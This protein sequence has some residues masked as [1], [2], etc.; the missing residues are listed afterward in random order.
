MVVIKKINVLS[1]AKL[2]TVF[3]ALTGLLLGL[4]V[5]ILINI[6]PP[7]ANE[8]NTFPSYGLLTT[9]VF[10]PIIYGI[11]GFFI[12]LISSLLYNFVAKY[13]GGIEIELDK[14]N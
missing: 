1:V 13:I 6:L 2:Y 5:N 4:M 11:L 14:H 9:L 12:G 10:F 7:T 3:M 8:I